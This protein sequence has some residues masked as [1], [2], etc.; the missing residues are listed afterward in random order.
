MNILNFE[1]PELSNSELKAICLILIL[2]V[3]ALCCLCGICRLS[4]P[5]SNYHHA[6]H[7]LSCC[8]ISCCAMGCSNSSKSRH[9]PHQTLAEN[10]PSCPLYSE[11]YNDNSRRTTRSNTYDTYA[12]NA[13]SYAAVHTAPNDYTN[14]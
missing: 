4:T 6:H 1:L 11:G 12:S 10:L 5:S 14:L 9:L 8:A 13:S 3:L 7:G 2:I